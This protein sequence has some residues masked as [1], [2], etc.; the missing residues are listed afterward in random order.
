MSGHRSISTHTE[1]THSPAVSVTR[2][3]DD[4][5]CERLVQLLDTLSSAVRVAPRMA[6]QLPRS[7]G[8]GRPPS[9]G[10][11]DGVPAPRRRR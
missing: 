9:L 11:W 1:I 2:R 7:A 10:Y 3:L 8:A 5:Q 6:A 4:E